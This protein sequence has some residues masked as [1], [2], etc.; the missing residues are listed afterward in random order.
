MNKIGVGILTHSRPELFKKLLESL[1][2]GINTYVVYAT[3]EA[4]MNAPTLTP[5]YH[6]LN[7]QCD[8]FTRPTCISWCKNQLLRMMINDDCKHLFLLEDDIEIA[9]PQVFEKYIAA[10]E[11]TGILSLCY[12]GDS[13]VRNAIDINGTSI[14]F[15][16]TLNRS[17][18]YYPKSFIKTLG[19]YDERYDKST[20]EHIDLTYRFIKAGVLPPWGWF[21]D[22][23]GSELLIHMSPYKKPS[24]KNSEE[25]KARYWYECSWFKH[26]YGSFHFQL[27]I[28]ADTAVLA[29]IEKLKDMYG[30]KH[31]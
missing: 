13:K 22:L 26:K 17:F 5:M 1:P 4:F 16:D 14:A 3:N 29:H 28:G 24:D 23:E 18:V 30:K 7:I 19:S 2:T 10:A 25:Y 12:K 11:N 15:A 20:I 8:V 6:A 27:P 31:E 9:D 21:A